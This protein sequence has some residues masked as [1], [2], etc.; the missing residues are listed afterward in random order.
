VKTHSLGVGFN[1]Y[2][3]TGD[4]TRSWLRSNTTDEDRLASYVTYSREITPN[5]SGQL[6]LSFEDVQTTQ[7]ELGSVGP[8]T[9][10]SEQFYSAQAQIQTVMPQRNL[11]ASFA[12][13]YTLYQG[14]GES[15]NISFF[16]TLI[17]HVG[18][19]DLNVTA[20]YTSADANVG[21]TSTSRQFAMVRFMIKR[22]LF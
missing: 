21:D 7:Y 17:W 9:D 15:T 11:N 16:S 22:K 10:L 4:V 1:A 20:S 6:S 5:T 19:L 12:T 13:N 18:L 2:P 8:T 14:L 3:F